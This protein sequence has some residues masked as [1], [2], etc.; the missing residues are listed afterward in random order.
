MQ[1][2]LLR[3]K[4]AFGVT[5]SP[6]QLL[7][8]DRQRRLE[9][10]E[11][12]VC[13]YARC[14]GTLKVERPSAPRPPHPGRWLVVACVSDRIP[15]DIEA[16]ERRTREGACFICALANGDPEYRRT[17]AMIYE[18][19]QVLVFLNRYPT[20][21]GYTLVCPRRHVERVVGDMTELE[22]LEVQRWVHR[23]GRALE[24]VVPTERLYVLS[25]GSQQG[26]RHVHWHVAPLPPG[27]P[28]HE[29][30]L[31]ALQ[32]SRG[33]IPVTPEHALQL[34]RQIRARLVTQ[35]E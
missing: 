34:A 26:N 3:S 7:A 9:H 17:N 30:Q 23:V 24:Q 22:Y 29:Q 35:Q 31:A 18:D 11:P 6:S 10:L 12:A 27:V 28:Y 4:P 25:L 5:A 15:F 14:Q 13:W 33:I 16:Y 8:S 1:T 2:A 19:S 20:L 32:M 21:R